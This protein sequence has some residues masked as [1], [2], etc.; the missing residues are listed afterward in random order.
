MIVAFADTH[1]L[2]WYVTKDPQLSLV[3]RTTFDDAIDQGNHI[4]FSTITLAEIIYL[5][6]KYRLPSDMY[7]RLINAIDIPRSVLILVP[8][9]RAA[10]DTMISV[11]RNEVPDMPDRIIAATAL[12]LEV[13]LITRD[14]KIQQSKVPT[15]W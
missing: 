6:E 5:V 11:D 13:P 10:A 7:K 14:A 1:T 8:F 2:I 15:I 3:A 12:A 9:H 4:G